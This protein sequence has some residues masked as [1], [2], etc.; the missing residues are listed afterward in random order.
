MLQCANEIHRQDFFLLN[1]FVYCSQIS[2]GLQA[3]VELD[4][5]ITFSNSHNSDRLIADGTLGESY[6][7]CRH[8]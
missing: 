1:Q 3:Y 6:M 4:P 2:R 8:C 7:H 5:A